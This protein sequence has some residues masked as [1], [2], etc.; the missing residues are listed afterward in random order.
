MIQQFACTGSLTNVGKRVNSYSLV[1]VDESGR[2]VTEYYKITASYGTLQI[3]PIVLHITANSAEK[4]YDGTA[5]TDAG[6]SVEGSVAAGDTLNVTVKGSQTAIGRSENTIT[7]I[8]IT[9][10]N[11]DDTSSNYKITYENGKLYVT[12]P[13]N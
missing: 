13:K 6:Y 10:E 12:P 5:L 8:S 1:I 9:N 4:A 3:T 7:A 11:G 2:D